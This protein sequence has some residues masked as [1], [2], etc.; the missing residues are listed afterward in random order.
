MFTLDV[1]KNEIAGEVELQGF[2]GT[3][4]TVVFK[5]T[6]SASSNAVVL[7]TWTVPLTF[8]NG[9]APYKLTNVPDGTLGLS[10]K[11]AWSLRRKL[12]VTLVSGQATNNFTTVSSYLKG[13]DVGTNPASANKVLSDDYFAVINAWESATTPSSDITGEGVVNVL[14]YSQV[15]EH[16]QKEGDPE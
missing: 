8:S 16:W 4:R 12:P 13:G 14:D 15:A 10:A 3:N 9:V 1:N 2:A 11:T 7:Q 6:D 5:A